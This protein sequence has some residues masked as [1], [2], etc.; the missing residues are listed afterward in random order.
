MEMVQHEAPEAALWNA[1]FLITCRVCICNS[2]NQVRLQL[3]LAFSL[4]HFS[5]LSAINGFRCRAAV[6]EQLCKCPP[7][8]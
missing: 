2:F 8:Q 3:G 6:F 5:L 7:L 4:R 1:W